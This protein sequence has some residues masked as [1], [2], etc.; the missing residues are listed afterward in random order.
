MGS[1]LSMPSPSSGA[2]LFLEVRN[3]KGFTSSLNP[4]VVQAVLGIRW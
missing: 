4:T 3:V 1:D 2:K